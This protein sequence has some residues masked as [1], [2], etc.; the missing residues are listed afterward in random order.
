[1]EGIGVPRTLSSPAYRELQDILTSARKEVGLTQAQLAAELDRPQSYVSKYENGERSL[2]VI[3]FVAV[4]EALGQAP[5]V[6]L[7]QVGGKLRRR[8]RRSAT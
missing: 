5:G 1:M 3:E 2:D 8:T 6:L 4:C 7:E